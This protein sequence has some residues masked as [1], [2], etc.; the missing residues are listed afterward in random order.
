MAAPSIRAVLLDLDGTLL[1]TAPDMA[2][3]LNKLRWERGVEPLPFASIRPYVSHGAATL[4]RVGFPDAGESEL[5]ELRA[6]FLEIYRQDVVVAT[7]LFPG[8]EQVLPDL[9]ARSVPW[10]IVTNK[11]AFL[12]EPLLARLRMQN[13]P[14]C[15]VSGDTVAK[16]KPD[17]APLLH[18]AK[19]LEIDPSACLYVGDAQRDIQAGRAA[20]MQTLV[21]LFGYIGEQDDPESWEADGYIGSPGEILDWISSTGGDG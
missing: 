18:A 21:A 8:F 15:V 1:D 17:P 4:V 14:A 19:L 7:Q 3:A 16:R 20:G 12:T 2:A 9:E 6:R 10:G 5:V 13:K 11:P